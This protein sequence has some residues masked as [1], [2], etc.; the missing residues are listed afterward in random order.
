MG[1]A[2]TSLDNRIPTFR[3]STAASSADRQN[4]RTADSGAV[5]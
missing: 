1:C 3:D 5:G 2:T 4:V